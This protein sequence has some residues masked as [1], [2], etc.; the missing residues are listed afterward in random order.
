MRG[1]A[2]LVAALLIGGTP[3]PAQ[4]N[5]DLDR[6]PDML[7]QE[8]PPAAPAEPSGPAPRA[9]K[10]KYYV[11]D[12]ATATALRH[13]PVP[14]PPPQPARW[15]NR[16]SFDATDQWDL[17]P[18]LTFSLSDRFNVMEQNNFDFPS[19]ENLRNDFREG[20]ATWEPAAGNYVEAGRINVRNGVALGFNPTDFFK[21]RTQID[22]ASLDPSVIRQN[23]LGVGM[24]RGQAIWG[25]G[26]VSAAMA[27]RLDNPSS[28]A[29]QSQSGFA[30]R[31]DRTNGDNRALVT[32]A[33]D[34]EEFSPQALIFRDGSRTIFGFNASHGIGR[35]IIAYTEWAG[36]R[37]PNLITQALQFG[38]ETGTFPNGTRSL[39]PTDTGE[40]FRNDLAAGLSWSSEYKITVNAE[41]HYH[42]AGLSRRE[43]RDW[44]DTGGA[45]RDNPSVTNQ[46][47]FIRGFA[48]D[49]QQLLT[50]HR[51]FLRAVWTDAFV[52]QLELAA[53][54]L[55]NL[56]DGSSLVQASA[57][58]FI[59]DRWTVAGYLS[60]NIGEPKSERGCA[61]QAASAILQL[62][63]YF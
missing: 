10:G 49:Q 22:Q 52:P 11:E 24:V 53:F 7:Q 62:V 41:Y 19:H 16:T 63:R 18:T 5:K 4:E 56:Y 48:A 31:F 43:W 26:S 2:T 46:L 42:Q 29:S 28:L 8:A 17:S 47:W 13:V 20:F 44:F 57:T 34:V 58:Y 38:R 3:V 27:P 55:V 51:A 50:R 37:Q 39:I 12:A 61:P 1:P 36:G 54:A 60:G 40:R 6:I 9:A 33:Y 30:P 35:S 15:Q 32:F 21:P 59:S 23:R 45:Q 14:F 25:S